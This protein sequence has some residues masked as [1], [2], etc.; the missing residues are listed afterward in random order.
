MSAP[1]KSLLEFLGELGDGLAGYHPDAPQKLAEYFIESPDLI[2]GNPKAIREAARLLEGFGNADAYMKANKKTWNNV[3]LPLMLAA[4]SLAGATMV[5]SCMMGLFNTI[6]QQS[7]APV[8]PIFG[9]VGGIFMAVGAV[10]G[11]GFGVIGI[12]IAEN[13]MTKVNIGKS[14]LG[15][16]VLRD[17][18]ETVAKASHVPQ[19]AINLRMNDF[20]E[21]EECI[22]LNIKIRAEENA[23]NKLGGRYKTE[24]RA[25]INEIGGVSA[26]SDIDSNAEARQPGLAAVPEVGRV[27]GTPP[28]W[29]GQVAKAHR[30]LGLPDKEPDEGVLRAAA[31][32]ELREALRVSGKP[33]ALSETQPNPQQTGSQ[34][35]L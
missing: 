7:N 27:E 1:R 13:V 33:N 34:L 2:A 19:A 12:Q 35:K 3:R 4:S 10:L 14:L 6:N 32:S 8:A 22:L 16:N 23:V 29:V 9:P 30:E 31:V 26:V 24:V 11:F 21:L 25:A 28:V 18:Y 17:T 20:R 15:L 5:T